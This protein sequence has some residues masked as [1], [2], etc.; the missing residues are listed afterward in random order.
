MLCSSP[1]AQVNAHAT[2]P[3]SKTRPA[4]KLAAVLP[5]IRRRQA[6]KPLSLARGGV[7][8]FL[9]Q[10][11][12]YGTQETAAERCLRGAACSVQR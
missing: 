11:L 4:E 12:T 5:P 1:T 8:L 3:G 2:S 7:R 6:F 10:P 9:E